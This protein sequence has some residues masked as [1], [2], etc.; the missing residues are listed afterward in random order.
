MQSETKNNIKS[1]A[2]I[3][4]KE[5]DRYMMYPKH[6]SGGFM[7]YA[8][9]ALGGA[10]LGGIEG[11][12]VDSASKSFT[13]ALTPYHPS[14]SNTFQTAIADQLKAKGYQVEIVPEP[15]MK[16]GE[17]TYDLTKLNGNYD[18]VLVASLKAGYWVFDNQA[19][20]QV[21]GEVEVTDKMGVRKVLSQKY[22]Y[23]AKSIKGWTQITPDAKYT[24]QNPEEVN[25]NA[26]IA[27]E[28]FNDGASLIA[29][30]VGSEF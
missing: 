17:K 2:I 23:N 28:S 26:K 7:L 13:E 21:S 10:I 9:G 14:V 6:M 30:K 11:G 20:P 27:A 22:A 15:P 1:I 29:Q 19:L 4:T 25:Q 5:P 16:E 12:K 24:I 8:F 18:A 3:Q